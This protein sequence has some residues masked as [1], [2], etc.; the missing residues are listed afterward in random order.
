MYPKTVQH[1]VE[2][3]DEGFYNN[4]IVHDYKSGSDMLTGAY[5][6]S[7]EDE[8]YAI[9]TYGE[10]LEKN[11]KEQEYYD[12]FN[13]GKLTPSVYDSVSYDA[14]GNRTVSS[15]NALATLIGEF[16][17]NNHVIEKNALTAK[18][19]ALKMYY[20]DKGTSNKPATVQNWAGQVLTQ[21]YKYNCAT[22][23]FSMQIGSSSIGASKYCV[24]ADLKN[25]KAKKELEALIEAIDAYREEITASKFE[26]TGVKTY[27]DTLDTFAPEDGRHIEVSF[28]MTSLPI[29]I[30]SVKITKH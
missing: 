2:L 25:D 30:E 16:S 19:G 11:Y 20:Y 12:L 9:S 13:A 3:A 7:D 28:T 10:Y 22:S 4:M 24:F 14:K 5:S 29:V 27:V 17:D 6:Y 26:T 21:D 23:V 8:L 18:V 1:F 15:D